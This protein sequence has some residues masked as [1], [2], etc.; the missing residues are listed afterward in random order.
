VAE[1]R[2]FKAGSQ[3]VRPHPTE[4]DCY[5]QVLAGPGGAKR[6]HLSTFGSDER[7]SSPKSSQSLQ[8]GQEAARSLLEILETTFPR[9]RDR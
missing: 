6:L 1:I 9:L 5:Y 2:A 7:E 3:E 8:L 4:V